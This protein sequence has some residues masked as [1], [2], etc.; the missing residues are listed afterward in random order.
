M[1]LM[2]QGMGIRKMFQQRFGLWPFLLWLWLAG[3]AGSHSPAVPSY[4]PAA[5]LPEYRLGFGD[6]IEVRFY[7]HEQFNRTQTI[8]PDGRITLERIG[9]VMA[10]GLTPTQLDSAI[11]EKYRSFV[12]DPELTVFVQEFGSQVVA[13]LGEVKTPGLYPVSG[14]TTPLDVIAA[15]GGQTIA[16]R[17]T[18]VILL[19]RD[20]QGELV[21]HRL[22]LR[23]FDQKSPMPENWLLRGGDIL[24]V[25]RTVI[26]SLNA[27]MSQVYDTILPPIDSW[28]RALFWYR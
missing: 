2:P 13:V 12:L 20:R 18:S 21:P 28:L 25:P 14:A 11:T 6:V 17:L 15:A 3:C 10:A 16:A 26:G 9:D 8:R 4:D 1:M 27:F 22:D 24:Y 23:R 19:R 5:P 7:Q